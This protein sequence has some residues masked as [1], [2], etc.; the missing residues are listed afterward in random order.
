MSRDKFVNHVA[1]ISYEM[2]LNVAIP[3]CYIVSVAEKSFRVQTLVCFYRIGH[4]KPFHAKACTL[5]STFATETF[6]CP[7]PLRGEKL[8]D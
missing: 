1:A 8:S 5:N 3:D 7:H 2:I 6:S 4:P